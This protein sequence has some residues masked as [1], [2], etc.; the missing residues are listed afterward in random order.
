M[1]S[2]E[3]VCS[4]EGVFVATALQHRKVLV[5]SGGPYIRNLLTLLE[6]LD[7]QNARDGEPL[8]AII[9]RHPFDAV[10]L[11]LRWPDLKP[12]DEVRGLGEVRP[13]WEGNLLVITAQI[14]GPETLD[15]L[16][17]YLINGLQQALLC[18]VS[19]HYQSPQ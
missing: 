7:G 8:L 17:R 19:H 6:K 15:M 13:A 2:A 9:N 4:W 16:E 10:V 11:D 18:L 12:T 3:A 5:L 14:N 1:L